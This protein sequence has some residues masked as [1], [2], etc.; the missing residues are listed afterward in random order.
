MATLLA[1]LAPTQVVVV[2]V[3]VVDRSPRLSTAEDDHCGHGEPNT[4]WR[5]P[6]DLAIVVDTFESLGCKQRDLIVVV[7]VVVL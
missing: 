4:C 6:A 2:V 5:R 3:A 1:S 7:V